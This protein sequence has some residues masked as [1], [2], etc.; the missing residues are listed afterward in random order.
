MLSPTSFFNLSSLTLI[1]TIIPL[2]R[3]KFQDNLAALI[4]G[5]PIQN[6]LLPARQVLYCKDKFSRFI[7]SESVANRSSFLGTHLL[8]FLN[9]NG[10]RSL[11]GW[12]KFLLVVYFPTQNSQVPDQRASN[13]PPSNHI[14]NR[15][16]HHKFHNFFNGILLSIILLLKFVV[17]LDLLIPVCKVVLK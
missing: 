5:V 11:I 8:S 15:Y 12:N 9:N 17:F 1:Y 7:G 13:L 16:I 10:I 3:P 4:G 14:N 2:H 6:P